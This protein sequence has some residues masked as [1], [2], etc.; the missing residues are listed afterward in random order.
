MHSLLKHCVL[1]DVFFFTGV[2]DTALQ[3]AI[4]FLRAFL[5]L[6]LLLLPLLGETLNTIILV[7]NRVPMVNPIHMMDPLLMNTKQ[8]T[9][10]AIPIAL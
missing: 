4:S 5:L 9:H 3:V 7:V 6:L 1:W 2:G 10:C 8:Q